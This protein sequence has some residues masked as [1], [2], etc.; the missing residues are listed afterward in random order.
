M[1]SNF[2]KKGIAVAVLVLALV[3]ASPAH[4]S[5]LSDWGTKAPTLLHQAWQ[6]LAN[7][8]PGGAGILP[9]APAATPAG[10][11]QEKSGLGV[12]PNGTPV[13]PNGGPG[14]DPNG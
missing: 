9:A 11:I 6:W 5:G 12:D 13:V 3:A 8:L 10:Q 4:A 7:A 2:R 14:V 1:S